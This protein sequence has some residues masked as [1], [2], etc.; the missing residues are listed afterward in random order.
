M[1]E[2][3]HYYTKDGTPMHFVPKKNGNGTRPTTIADCRKLGLLPSVT[4]IL[5]VLDKPALNRWMIR[6]AVAAVVTAPDM[7]GEGLDAKIE[8]VLDREQQQDEEAQKA[9][10]LGTDI[11]AAIELAAQGRQCDPEFRVY[12]DP[13]LIAVRQWGKVASVERILVGDGFAGKA[14]LIMLNAD[15][16][17]TVVDFKTTK[18]L[19]KFAYPEHKLQLSAYVKASGADESYNIYISTEE[20]GKIAICP[21]GTFEDYQHGFQHLVKLWQWL[22]NYVPEQEV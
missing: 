16:I 7:A 12:V 20:P 17:L 15:T 19:P 13:V 11:H 10:D 2:S 18:K 1:I 4:Q 8:R 21:S 3:G 22:N 14:D 5:R 6:Q 9:R